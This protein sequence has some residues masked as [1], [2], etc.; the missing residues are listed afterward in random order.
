[1]EVLRCVF[2]LRLIAAA[3]VPTGQAESEVDPA[4][5]SGQAFFAAVRGARGDL[6]DLIQM[7]ALRLHGPSLQ[8]GWG[9]PG[10]ADVGMDERHGHGTLADGG[11]DALD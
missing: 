2:P 10:R 11:C 4:P 3:D 5:T 8:L 6:S 1:M 7:C 9:L